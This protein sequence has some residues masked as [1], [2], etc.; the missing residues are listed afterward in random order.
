M[1]ELATTGKHTHLCDVLPRCVG[2]PGGILGVAVPRQITEIHPD[3]R[4]GG[5]AG[6][7]ERRPAVPVELQEVGRLRDVEAHV[8]PQLEVLAVKKSGNM[9]TWLTRAC[10]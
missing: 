5:V 1:L 3:R 4:V 7:Q 6:R 8:V 10:H 9:M 2:L